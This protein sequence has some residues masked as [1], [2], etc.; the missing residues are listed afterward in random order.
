VWSSV[1][2]V[3]QNPS[4]IPHHAKKR[5]FFEDRIPNRLFHEF[6]QPFAKS[7]CIVD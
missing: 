1:N 4:P 7:I 6:T 3:K 5:A 2:T